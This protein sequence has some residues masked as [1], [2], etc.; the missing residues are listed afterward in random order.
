[1]RILL[2]EDSFEVSTAMVELLASRDHTAE[3]VTNVDDAKALLALD[4]FDLIVLDLNLPGG[5][6][7]LLIE[8]CKSRGFDL[9][10]FVVSARTDLEDR[11]AL[12]ES[13]ADDYLVKPFDP[14][15]FLARVGALLRRPKAKAPSTSTVGRLIFD[16]GERRAYHAMTGVDI[17]LTP[18]ERSALAGLMQKPGASLRKE[19]LTNLLYSMESDVQLSAVEVYVSRLRTKL[20]KAGAGVSIK[21]IRGYGYRLEAHE[22]N[23]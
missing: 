21:S 8:H 6:G 1:M 9:P 5:S 11:V 20:E 22:A 23:A 10:I 17:H 13:G 18:R 14:F 15:E 12:L 19:A 4:Y 16:H 3:V 7:H 2:V